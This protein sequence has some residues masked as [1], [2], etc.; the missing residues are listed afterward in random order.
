[1]Y[2]EDRPVAEVAKLTGVPEGT[3]KS[4]TCQKTARPAPDAG[5]FAPEPTDSRPGNGRAR[6]GAVCARDGLPPGT[7]GNGGA[8]RPACPGRRAAGRRPA[9]GPA[10]PPPPPLPPL[11]P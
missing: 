3:V 4:G 7:A 8:G 1:M 5:A 10:A 2:V 6:T 11:P 9:R